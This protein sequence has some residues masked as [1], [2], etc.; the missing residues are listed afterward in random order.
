M[1]AIGNFLWFILGGF[2]MGLGQGLFTLFFQVRKGRKQRQS[3]RATTARPGVW[4]RRATMSGAACAPFPSGCGQKGLA[5][6]YEAWPGGIPRL[7]FAPCA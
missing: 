4:P 5:R 6:R 1:R 7:H 2:F 3:R